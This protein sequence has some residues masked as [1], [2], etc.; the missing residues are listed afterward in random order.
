MDLHRKNNL[1]TKILQYGIFLACPHRT[2]QL[3]NQEHRTQ[4]EASEA[5][6]CLN[7]L[8]WGE[9]IKGQSHSVVAT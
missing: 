8:W 5:L 7:Y 4:T 2:E 3:S 6:C 1:K 9:V